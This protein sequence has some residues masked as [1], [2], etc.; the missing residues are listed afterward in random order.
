MERKKITVTSTVNDDTHIE[1]IELLKNGAG[2]SYSQW[3]REV[4]EKEL[5]R[6]K[7]LAAKVS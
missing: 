3:L 1:L 6:L 2:K 4:E 5:N 7:R